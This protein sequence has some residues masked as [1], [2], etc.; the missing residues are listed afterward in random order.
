[1][2]I[3]ICFTYML[4]VELSCIR[5]PDTATR[6]CPRFG[7][8][9][10]PSGAGSWH[11][12]CWRHMPKILPPPCVIRQRKCFRLAS[13]SQWIF[14]KLLRRRHEVDGRDVQEAAEGN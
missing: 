13:I 14:P 2:E 6:V 8:G 11:R 7:S 10:R 1:M 4:P 9:I 3:T 12:Q 5:F